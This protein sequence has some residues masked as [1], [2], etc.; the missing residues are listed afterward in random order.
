MSAQNQSFK[1]PDKKPTPTG[2]TFMEFVAVKFADAG[3][4]F[5]TIMIMIIIVNKNPR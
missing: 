5:T 4:M 2:L 1:K 3:F